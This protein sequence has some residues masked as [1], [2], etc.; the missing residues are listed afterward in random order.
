MDNQS[1]FR[2]LRLIFPLAVVLL[3]LVPASFARN[4]EDVLALVNEVPITRR[5]LKIEIA[6]LEAQLKQRNQTLSPEQ[7]PKLRRQLMENLIHRELLHQKAQKKKIK[8]QN[9]WVD[10]AF[11]ELKL[12]LGNPSAYAGYLE[13]ALMDEAQ[14]KTRIQKGLIVRRLLRREVLRRIKVSE[15][16]MRAFYRKYP[17][18][19]IRREQVRLRQITITAESSESASTRAK[20]LLRIQTIQDKLHNGVNFAAL[21]LEYSEDSSRSKGGDLGYLAHGQI[22]KPVADAAFSLDPGQVSDIVESHLGFHLIQMVHKI[23]SSQMA[24]RNTRTK[25]E[26]TL[27]RNKENDATE[28]YLAKLVGQSSIQRLA[29]P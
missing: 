21:A 2:L 10:K 25:I 22:I 28:N 4:N 8:I 16:E 29:R 14:F 11:A 27:R 17:E 18:F 23:P 19:F 5:D 9:R 7:Q 26:R 20:A 6:L 15:A 1:I 3:Y 13:K 12:K 24:Y